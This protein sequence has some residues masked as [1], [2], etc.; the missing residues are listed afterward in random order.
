M[1]QQKQIYTLSI[2]MELY[3]DLRGLAAREN[4]SIDEVLRSAIRWQFILDGILSDGG[5]LFVRYKDSTSISPI[6]FGEK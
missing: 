4:K 6:E 1:E 3:Q 2:P 5:R